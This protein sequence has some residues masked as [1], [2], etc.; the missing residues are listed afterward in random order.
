MGLIR[1]TER[2]KP[3]WMV[4][5]FLQGFGDENLKKGRISNSIRLWKWDKFASEICVNHLYLYDVN[6]RV[7]LH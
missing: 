2:F 7:G 5:F 3:F 6:K 4:C 1:N